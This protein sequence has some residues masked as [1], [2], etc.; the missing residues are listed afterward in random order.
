LK[1]SSNIVTVRK[2]RKMSRMGHVA[3]MGERRNV[4]KTL[5]GKPERKRPSR[6]R[7]HE[8]I[9]LECILK[10]YSVR[11]W[12]RYICLRIGVSGCLCKDNN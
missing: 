5:V 12:N 1:A 6:R 3:R 8:R 7:R 9:I 2:S 11:L 10:K 4:S